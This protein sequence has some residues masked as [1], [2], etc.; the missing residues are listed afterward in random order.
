MSDKLR[1]LNNLRRC[2]RCL[3]PETHETIVFDREGV[4]NICRQIEYKQNKVEWTA[5][6]N[7]FEELLHRYRGK[8]E[9]S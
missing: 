6:R 8:N 7:D 3:I 4:C 2:S 9:G 5:K 1:V